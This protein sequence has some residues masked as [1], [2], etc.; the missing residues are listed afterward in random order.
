M[1]PYFTTDEELEMSERQCVSVDCYMKR[2]SRIFDGF[3]SRD[4]EEPW[5]PPF[6]EQYDKQPPVESTGF[7]VTAAGKLAYP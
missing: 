4:R 5:T 1:T 7:E 3:P 2:R 6:P